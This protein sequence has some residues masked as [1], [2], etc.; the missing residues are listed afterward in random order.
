MIVLVL[1][2]VL[3]EL[4]EVLFLETVCHFL[5]LLVCRFRKVKGKM[6]V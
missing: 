6:T 3:T 5:S 2:E 1:A 4:E